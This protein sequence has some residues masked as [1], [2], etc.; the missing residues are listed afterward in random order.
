MKRILLIIMLT[1]SFT[2]AGEIFKDYLFNQ[3]KTDIDKFRD[4][5]KVDIPIF[6]KGIKNITA[7]EDK[8][9][10]VLIF[11]KTE[12]TE[13]LKYVQAIFFNFNL[14]EK[15]EATLK[16]G[17]NLEKIMYLDKDGEK[18]VKNVGEVLS[19]IKEARDRS[20]LFDTIINVNLGFKKGNAYI[21][22]MY[23]SSIS[24]DIPNCKTC[25]ELEGIRF[26]EITYL[27]VLFTEKIAK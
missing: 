8:E 27:T 13:K 22:M 7:Y 20:N 5:K 14:K 3:E 17:F 1:F 26:K 2:Q 21:L 19:N 16:M 15:I 4:L 10:A 24:R 18:K 6:F 23:N 9:N 25:E 11:E 12:K